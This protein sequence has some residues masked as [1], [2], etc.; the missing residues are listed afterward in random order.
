M[1]ALSVLRTVLRTGGKTGAFMVTL[2]FLTGAAGGVT[3]ANDTE[4]AM[5]IV[6]Q[7]GAALD[8][9]VSKAAETTKAERLN[10]LTEI[11]DANFDMAR[12]GANIIGPENYDKWDAAQRDA[13]VMGFIRYMIATNDKF[14]KLY[15]GSDFAVVGADPMPR[16]LYSVRTEYR[17][18]G[19]PDPV[20]IGFVVGQ[21]SGEWLILDVQ[22]QSAISLLEVKRAELNSVLQRKGFDGLVTL[23]N[24]IADKMVAE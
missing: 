2:V 23:M 5:A 21:K 15:R 24:K 9:V 22:E 10:A 16:G 20:K 4:E 7:T 6:E 12:V 3:S 17:I 1:V 14:I 13:Y 18:E 19:E 11:L 8:S